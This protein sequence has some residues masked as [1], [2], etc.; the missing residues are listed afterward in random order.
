MIV[1]KQAICKAAGSSALS[2]TLFGS[3]ARDEAVPGSDLDVFVVTHSRSDADSTRDRLAS[4]AEEIGALY[5]A[6]L[7]PVV[8]SLSKLRKMKRTRSS[9]LHEVIQDG[10]T[11]CGQPIEDLLVTRF[12]VGTL[13]F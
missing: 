9:F 5:H 11:L 7:S 1:I 3:T 10:I 12:L 13:C 2:V 6:E 4:G 8:Y